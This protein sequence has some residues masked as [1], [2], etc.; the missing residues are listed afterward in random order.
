MFASGCQYKKV[1]D[2]FCMEQHIVLRQNARNLL[3]TAPKL[4]KQPLR[5]VFEIFAV[6]IFAS[7]NALPQELVFGKNNYI[8][9]QIGTL[10]IV[11]SVPNGGN[12]APMAI[13]DRTQP[14][15]NLPLK[16][17]IIPILIQSLTN[18]T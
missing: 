14:A 9:Y 4:I 16:A 2:Q 18:N 3:I 8:E 15:T 7:S 6:I 5:M 1:A 13:F 11:I 12:L 10:P 17:K